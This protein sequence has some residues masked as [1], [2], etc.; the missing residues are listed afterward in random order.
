MTIEQ[1]YFYLDNT[2]GQLVEA[3][4]LFARE[5]IDMR[6]YSVAEND[7]YGVFR[8]L[9][10]EPDAAVAALRRGGIDA[11]KNRVLGIVVPDETGS[12]V[13]AFR[14]L[15]DAGIN[16][17]YSYA[18]AMAQL[19]QAFIVLRVNDNERAARLLGEA[20]VRLA[21]QGELF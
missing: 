20:G 1:V 2:P 8:M 17:R 15:A 13:E 10:R 16:V 9:V 11:A 21:E 18:F 6:A 4:R 14:I 3:L 12:T 19:K 7:E 5:G